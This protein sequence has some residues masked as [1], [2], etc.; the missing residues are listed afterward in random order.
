ML[1]YG[2]DD[3][4]MILQISQIDRTAEINI[5]PVTQLCGQNIVWKNQILRIIKNIF[6]VRNMQIMKKKQGNHTVRRRRNWKKIL[7]I[8]KIC[9]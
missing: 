2:K 7:S 5:E 3:C 8:N 1:R 4:H 9:R 6:P